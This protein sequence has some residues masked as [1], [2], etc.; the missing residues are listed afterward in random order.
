M[1]DAKDT[2]RLTFQS[3]ATARQALR[4]LASSYEE[5]DEVQFFDIVTLEDSSCTSAIL[6]E[7]QSFNE[8]NLR[9]LSYL[10][11]PGADIIASWED[12]AWRTD[13]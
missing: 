11:T 13:V 4:T 5:L 9:A 2:T 3:V 1:Q 12:G 10:P 6:A 8:F 7:D